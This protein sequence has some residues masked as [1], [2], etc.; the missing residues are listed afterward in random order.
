MGL[1]YGFSMK[2][3]R[4]G[5][6]LFGVAL[7]V[8]A[9]A[10]MAAPVAPVLA[11]STLRDNAKHVRTWNAFA[12][13]LLRIHRHWVALKPMTKTERT[14]GYAN[15]ADAFVE[16]SHR[17]AESG[18]LRS[19]IRWLKDDLKTPQLI[20]LFFYDAKGRVSHDFA[21]AYLVEFRNAPIQT[22]INIHYYD[23][24][25]HAFRQFDASGNRTYE[26]CRGT[27]FGAAVDVGLDEGSIP[28]SPAEV[29]PETYLA[30]FGF[31][32][33]EAG[34]YLDPATLVPEL[35]PVSPPESERAGNVDSRLASLSARLALTPDNAELHVERGQ[36]NFVVHRFAEA[37]ADFSRAIEIDPALDAGWFGRGLARGRTGD[38]AAAIADLGVYIERRPQSSKA[39]TKRGVRHIWNRDF[40]SA[41]RDL[42]RAVALDVKNAEA[43]DDLGVVLAQTGE[44]AGAIRHF[45]IARHLDP[46]YQKPHHNLAMALYMAGRSDAALAA[47]DDALR[48]DAQ[49]RGTLMLKGT[50]LDA[51]GRAEEARAIR[52]A[53]EFLPEGNWSE[54]SGLN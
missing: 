8:C 6:N 54:R 19:R 1:G 28:P 39:F 25:L 49:A 16:T 2:R 46:G 17:G 3:D 9:V 42:E 13:Q 52:D 18:L 41:R 34:R 4:S 37:V 26:S 31:L 20:E 11:Q 38:L 44:V 7:A 47:V 43:H 33:R 36:L 24:G 5:I 14:G 29:A 30:C 48:L 32:P 35:A 40:A 21:A 10:A 12:N 22:L 45:E 23:D 50:I 15:R 51:I 27:H 53:A